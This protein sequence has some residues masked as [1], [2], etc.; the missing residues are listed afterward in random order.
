MVQHDVNRAGQQIHRLLKLSNRTH[1]SNLMSKVQML[2]AAPKSSLLANQIHGK[3]SK[4][5]YCIPTTQSQYQSDNKLLKTICKIT[6]YQVYPTSS[7]KL[8][9]L[10]LSVI[11]SSSSEQFPASD[12]I[13]VEQKQANNLLAMPSKFLP[14]CIPCHRTREQYTHATV[15]AAHEC[16]FI[17]TAPPAYMSTSKAIAS[18]NHSYT[19]STNSNSSSRR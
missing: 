7:S 14:A 9:L 8:S 2:S 13:D 5:W 3:K 4:D 11:D 10:K 6:K 12:K 17:R 19:S 18:C 1:R 16:Y 15:A